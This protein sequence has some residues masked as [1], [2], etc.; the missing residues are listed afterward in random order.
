MPSVPRALREYLASIGVA[1]LLAWLAAAVSSFAGYMFPAMIFLMAVVISALRWRRGP[2]LTLATLS[3]LVWNFLFIPP[4][5][6][7]HIAKPE[8]AFMFAI[9]FL[10]ALSMGHLTSRLNEREQSLKLK[11]KETEVLLGIVQ[12]AAFETDFEAGLQTAVQLIENTLKNPVGI[13][14]NTPDNRPLLLLSEGFQPPSKTNQQHIRALSLSGKQAPLRLETNQQRSTW[15]ALHT[16]HGNFGAIGFASGPSER[17][18]TPDSER[19]HQAIR[20]HLSMVIEKEHL[21]QSQ[22]KT[23][24]L[25]ESE[26]LHRILFDSVSHELKTPIAIIRAALDGLPSSHAMTREIDT[27]SRRLQRILDNFLDM[28]RMESGALT[29]LREW[30]DLAEILESAKQI[31]FSEEPTPTLRCLG[32]DALPPIYLD[33]R[34]VAQ[35][36]GNLLHNAFIYAPQGSPVDLRAEYSSDTLSISVRDY[37]PGVP[38]EHLDAVFKKFFRI[39]GSLPGGTGLGLA[40]TR[41]L[42]NAQGG[43]VHLANCVSGGAEAIIS[44]PVPRM[45]TPDS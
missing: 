17:Q 24:M 30:T 34:L 21:L 8:D 19:L 33:G 6:T 1:A 26:R 42:I 36:L 31:A 39:P 25:A 15:L 38:P 22:R 12:T 45:P 10:V 13:H 7:L 28:N 16:S 44:L 23:A 43:S 20:L 14:V 35:A 37:G 32:F 5:F 40:I 2:V 27:A 3:A 4:R 9:F 11:Q 18:D 29:I 41:G